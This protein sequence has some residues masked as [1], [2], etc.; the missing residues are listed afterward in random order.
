M[1]YV[2]EFQYLEINNEVKKR[3]NEVK[4]RKMGGGEGRDGWKK[5]VKE[6]KG[7]IVR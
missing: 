7:T 6:K 5:A 4:E 1:T 3:N 2:Y